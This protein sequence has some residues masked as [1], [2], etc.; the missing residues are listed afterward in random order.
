[1]T[2]ICLNQNTLQSKNSERLT[3]LRPRNITT[4]TE[5]K[6][7]KKSERNTSVA[8]NRIDLT[9]RVY[10]LLKVRSYAYTRKG[11][12][13]WDCICHCGNSTIVGASDLRNSHSK[14]CGC[15]QHKLKDITNQ[16]FGRLTVI[17]FSFMKGRHSIW[18]C[19]CK[20]GNIINVSSNRLMV[21][22]TKSCG[23][24]FTE[25]MKTRRGNR[26]PVW[27]HDLTTKER[28]ENMRRNYNP[29][30]QAWRKRIYERDNY[31]CQLSGKRGVELCAHHISG[32]SRSES[33]RFRTSN[34]IT[35]CKELHS[36][37]HNLYGRRQNTA[38]QFSQFC[39]DYKTGKIPLT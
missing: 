6:S 17:R 39:E 32:W 7:Y 25:L 20:C 30:V 35:L 31:T 13:Y 33:L 36:L 24:L 23:C 16:K 27:R 5:K 9:G 4:K 22:D 3:T 15:L 34:G 18:E 19:K 38:K 10:N 29:R 37:F 2:P 26:S 14:S 8:H 1:M 21:G 28:V 11:H 12:A